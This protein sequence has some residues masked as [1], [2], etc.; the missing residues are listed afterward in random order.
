[1]ADSHDSGSFRP[2]NN[3]SRYSI[4]VPV[5]ENFRSPGPALYDTSNI[6]L[7]K[8]SSPQY[9]IGSRM[10]IRFSHV[11]GANAYDRSNY[12]PGR[13]APSYS[14]G[15]RYSNRSVPLILPDYIKH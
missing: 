12:K 3:I 13:T 1:M 4:M 10:K 9:S 14:F 2:L 5:N 7:V 6:S 8:S 11:P 15:R